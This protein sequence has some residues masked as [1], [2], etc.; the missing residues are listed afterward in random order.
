LS[1]SYGLPG[2]RS[3][4]LVVKDE[5]LRE[6]IVNWKFYTSICSAAPSEFLAEAAL[7]VRGPL[8]ARSLEQIVQNLKL[9]D[10]FFARW[11]GL[12]TWR[13]PQAGSIAL[14]WM[15]VTS[16]Q[17]YAERL[18]RDAGVLIQPATTLRWDDRHF[19][20]GLGRAGFGVA[21]E[22]FENYLL[23]HPVGKS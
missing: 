11:P 10:H 16:V 2:L 15:N 6:A 7:I 9:A 18:A 13:P 17:T 14:V 8:I 1:K 5:P 23:S 12:F 3:G 22:K 19:R 20:L 4:W 21:L